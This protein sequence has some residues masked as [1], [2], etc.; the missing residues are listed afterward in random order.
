MVLISHQTQ[1]YLFRIWERKHLFTYFLDFSFLDLFFPVAIE[2]IQ[3]V[4]L[5][6]LNAHGFIDVFVQPYFIIIY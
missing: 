2:D 3:P 4:N 5:L 6:F 1:F